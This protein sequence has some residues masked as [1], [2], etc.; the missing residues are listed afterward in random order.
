VRAAAAWGL[1]F[2]V[3]ADDTWSGHTQTELRFQHGAAAGVAAGC[4]E[5]LFVGCVS[6]DVWLLCIGWHRLLENGMV[7]E[8]RISVYLFVPVLQGFEGR[9]GFSLWSSCCGT[10][11][12]AFGHQT[13]EGSVMAAVAGLWH[14]DCTFIYLLHETGHVA[15][16][17]ECKGGG[18]IMSWMMTRLDPGNHGLE[19][20][21]HPV[22]L[23]YGSRQLEWLP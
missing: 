6:A 8:P 2:T 19:G 23:P 12:S 4:G 3:W 9:V 21:L 13:F 10:C 22:G 1:W 14:T 11:C 17:V 7:L 16:H 20:C 15:L 18:C 5:V